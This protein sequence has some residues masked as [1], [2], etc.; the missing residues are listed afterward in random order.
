MSDPDLENRNHEDDSKP[1]NSLVPQYTGL[2][3]LYYS[4]VTQVVLLGFVGFLEPGLFNAVTGL[5]G[6]GQIDATISANANSAVYAT[7]AAMAFFSGTVNNKLGP[8]LTLLLGT[9]GYSLFIGSYLSLNIHPHAGTFVI[10]SG[11]I[12]GIC[13]GLL[14]TAQGSLML[15]YPTENQKGKFIAIYWGIF[16]SGGVVG[17]AVSFGQNFHATSGG[18]GNGTYIAFIVLSALGALIPPLMANPNKMIRSDGSKVTAPRHPSWKTEIYGLYTTLRTD[19]AIILLFPMFFASNWFYTWQFNDYNGTLFNIRTRSL[20][21][22]LYW[23]PEIFGSLM[24]GLILDNKWFSRRA[25]AFIGWTILFVTV[26]IV[27][28]WAYFYQKDY[29]RESIP[30]LIDFK[31]R[32]YPQHVW[33]YI[34]CGLL[35]SMWQATV[36]WIIGAVSNDLGKLAYLNGFYR[37]FQAA[38]AAIVWRIDGLKVPFMSIFLSTWILLVAGL[39]CAL[40]MLIVRVKNHTEFEDEVAGTR[41]KLSDEKKQEL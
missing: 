35:D 6:G 39:L 31:D 28:V 34:F 9:L 37:A 21:N 11:A 17:S 24:M 20:N 36:Y 16:T 15:A 10:A 19:P 26:F 25:R 2:K 14:W 5:G 18:V 33:L 41:T 27:H 7:F 8:R 29:T 22:M 38:G 3:R 12:L 40:P 30:P 32:T 23:T 13:G 4:P 1:E